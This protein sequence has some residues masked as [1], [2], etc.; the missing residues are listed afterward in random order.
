MIRRDRPKSLSTNNW[1]NVTN[2]QLIRLVG[3]KSSSAL[4]S[5]IGVTSPAQL[6]LCQEC[7]NSKIHCTLSNQISEE[8]DTSRDYTPRRN[9]N[10]F[11]SVLSPKGRTPCSMERIQK[12]LDKVSNKRRTKCI[13]QRARCDL[14]VGNLDFKAS[15]EDLIESIHPLLKRTGI[16]LVSATVPLRKG[17]NCGY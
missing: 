11:P 6:H 9:R 13:E 16:R 5:I 4:N 8:Q 3:S 15:A 14:C 2:K 7:S 12:T 1:Q 10:H 17:C